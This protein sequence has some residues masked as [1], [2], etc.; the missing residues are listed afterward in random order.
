MTDHKEHIELRSDEVQEI[1]SHVPHWMIRWGN[2]MIFL[3]I[4]ILIFISWF[5]KYPDVISGSVSL[6]TMQQTT[7][8]VSKSSGEI[9]FLEKDNL[10]VKKGD[11]L[12]SIKT[13]LTPEAKAYLVSITQAIDFQLESNQIDQKF[14]D[15]GMVFGALHSDYEVL[16]KGVLD[17]QYFIEKNGSAFEIQN[18]KQQIKN[19]TILRSVTYQQLNAKQELLSQFKERYASSE[20]LY[21]NGAISKVK[22]YEEKEKLAQAQNSLG[23]TKKASVQSSIT[24]TE[25]K[26]QLHALELS[27]EKQRND[28]LIL[29]QSKLTTIKNALIDW[30]NTYEL[31][32]NTNGKLAHLQT[33]SLNQHIEGGK[34]LFAIIPDNQQ[35]IGHIK[36]P[37]QGYGKL[38]SGQ[39]VRVKLD[40]YPY[41][42]YGQLEGTVS[43]IS[44]IP[45]ED[46]YRVEFSLTNGMKSSYGKTF[47]YTPEMS[48]TAEIITEDLR[49]IER[50]FNKFRSITE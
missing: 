35:Y 4:A 43:S 11:L 38:K 27:F 42:E 34:E 14:I 36:I 37:K 39:K 47:V 26:K 45:N 21:S 20:R 6:S 10:E 40:N 18:L 33:L 31:R 23:E 1:M 2:T 41:H 3:L 48:G 46:S 9:V 19:H 44:L 30:E 15:D 25:L 29:I 8:L 49:L 7:K 5:I 22:L 12:G 17:Y 50:I 16:K 28:F 13:N 32:A 24:I